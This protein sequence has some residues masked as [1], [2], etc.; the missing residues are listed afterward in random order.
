VRALAVESDPD[1]LEQARKNARINGLR[2]MAARKLPAKRSFDLVFANVLSPVLLQEKIAL[3][4]ALRHGGILLLS[5]I[6]RADGKKFLHDFRQPGLK[7]IEELSE[8]DW[9]GFALQ[10]S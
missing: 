8:G 7:L 10:K 9:I 5:G 4:R 3:S 1:A 2:Y 6:L